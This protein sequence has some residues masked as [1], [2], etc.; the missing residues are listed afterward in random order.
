MPSVKNSDIDSQAEKPQESEVNIEIRKP[1]AEVVDSPSP[2][3]KDKTLIKVD[4]KLTEDLTPNTRRKVFREAFSIRI[5]RADETPIKAFT[6]ETRTSTI[7]AK[8]SFSR[9][10]KAQLRS[11]YLVNFIVD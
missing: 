2:E 10:E 1:G 9:E 6:G 3:K 8:H 7:E 4:D 5:S 11:M